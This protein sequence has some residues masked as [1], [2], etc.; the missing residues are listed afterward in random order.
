M[1]KPK[2]LQEYDV[3]RIFLGLL[4]PPPAPIHLTFL[5]KSNVLVY[6]SKE[7]YAYAKK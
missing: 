2:E 3:K 6:P 1:V 4:P 5:E 7:F